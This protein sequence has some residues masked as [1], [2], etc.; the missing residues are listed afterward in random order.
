LEAILQGVEMTD[1]Y[2]LGSGI[3][4]TVQLSM[5]T[6]QAL[7]TI[8]R[9]Y[10]LHD[11][12]LVLDDIKQYCPDV[13]DLY[14]MYHDEREIRRDVYE[15]IARRIVEDACQGGGAL[16]FIV[17]G[18]PLFLVSASEYILHFARDKGLVA[19]ALPAVSSFDTMLCDLEIDLGYGVQIFDPTTMILN[20][21]H[22][23]PRVPMLLFQLAT[24][25]NS[26]VLMSEPSPD[27]LKPLQ[28]FLTG[29][30]PNDHKCYFLH[31]SS[32]I[33]EHAQKVECEIGSLSKTEGVELWKRPTLYV[34]GLQ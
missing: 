13:I 28:D 31:S 4:G 34:P 30:Y 24:L 6:M 22:P 19:R 15:A 16:A 12:T 14:S 18:H 11:D 8:R 29:H 33:L 1:L 27:I 10:V 20:K 17:H 23:N 21:W 32:H 9:A 25:M 2:I 3:H 5:E 7:S 26:N